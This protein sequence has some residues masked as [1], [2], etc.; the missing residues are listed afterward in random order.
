MANNLKN[1]RGQIYFQANKVNKG[2]HVFSNKYGEK[3]RNCF[4]PVEDTGKQPEKHSRNRFISKQI[5]VK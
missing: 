2:K 5:V 3:M 1:T 4:H